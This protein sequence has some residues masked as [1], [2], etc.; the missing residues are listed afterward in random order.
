MNSEFNKNVDLI[1][2]LERKIRLQEKQINNLKKSVSKYKSLFDYS[3]N[4]LLILDLE[5]NFI[6]VNKIACESY[7]YSFNEFAAIKYFNLFPK[8]EKKRIENDFYKTIKTDSSI[9]QSVQISKKGKRT[10]VELI[11]K[12]IAFNGSNCMLIIAKDISNRQ[13]YEDELEKEKDLLNALMDNIPDTIYFK[14]L[15]SKFTRINKAQANLLG[16][17]N[18]EDAVGKTDS[19]FF[20]AK[21]AKGSFKDEK[22]ILETKKLLVSKLEHI[23]MPKNKSKWVSATKVPIYDKTG[24]VTGLVGMSRDITDLKKAENQILKYAK[25]L[26]KLNT[27]KDKFFSIIAHDLKNPFF[28]L[29]GFGELLVNNQEVL[30]EEEKTEYINNILKISRNSY[31]LLEN[32]LQWSRTQ[33]GRIEFCP[34]EIDLMTLINNSTEFFNPIAEQKKITIEN[35]IQSSLNVYADPDMMQT[36]MRNL[37]TNAIKFTHPGGCIQIKK[38][39]DGNNHKIIVSD[40]GIGM[41]PDTLNNIF[42]IDVNH[43]TIGTS[44]EVGTGLGLIICKEFVEKNGGIIGV[45]SEVGKG[46]QFSFTLPKLNNTIKKD[47]S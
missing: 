15:D 22:E 1:K 39:G 8:S 18:C 20:S 21:D 7:G 11:S 31:Q 10:P 12:I 47:E 33:T 19:N 43:K 24:N 6:E 29:L 41:H 16:L 45:S 36:I 46:T 17:K 5:G 30:S 26:Q 28:S 2:D 25:E 37:I 44:N 14:D 13:L 4:A 3:N 34:Q 38:I 27:T 9:L 40:N 35:K 23:K 42:R 32:L